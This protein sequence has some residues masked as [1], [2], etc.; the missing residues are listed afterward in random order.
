MAGDDVA[1]QIK[2]VAFTRQKH[3]KMEVLEICSKIKKAK[4]LHLQLK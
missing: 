3:S 1:Q 4:D 2:V